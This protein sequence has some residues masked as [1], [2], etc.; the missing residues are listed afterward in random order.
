MDGKLVWV[1]WGGK[2]W[3]PAK[4]SEEIEGDVTFFGTCAD[5]SEN[6]GEATLTA[7]TPVRDFERCLAAGV[8][9]GASSIPEYDRKAF[10]AA[11][12]AALAHN[13]FVLR[14][15][16]SDAGG[17]MAEQPRTPAVFP[18][19]SLGTWSKR[20]D[21]VLGWLAAAEKDVNGDLEPP[22][23]KAKA[24]TA[25]AKAAKVAPPAAA[26]EGRAAAGKAKDGRGKAA[27]VAVVA[28]A[29]TKKKKQQKEK[30][31]KGR[32]SCKGKAA[33][34]AS[35]GGGS[36]SSSSSSSSI[37]VVGRSG[38]QRAAVSYVDDDDDDE[39]CEDCAH[40][41]CGIHFDDRVHG[42]R[43]ADRSD[44][45]DGHGESDAS[46]SDDDHDSSSSEEEMVDDS[47]SNSEEEQEED[48]EVSDD[49]DAFEEQPKKRKTTAKKNP[50]AK[51]AAAAAAGG[52]SASATEAA[53]APKAAA[54]EKDGSVSK[55]V[56]KGVFASKLQVK[57]DK[58]TARLL[59]GYGGDVGKW[60][61]ALPPSCN[62]MDPPVEN[63]TRFGARVGGVAAKDGE[64]E[65]EGEEGGKGSGGAAQKS[66]SSSSSSASTA[67]A[68]LPPAAEVLGEAAL[69]MLAK[70]EYQVGLVLGPTG[71][72]KTRVLQVRLLARG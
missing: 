4:R 31:T 49:S 12:D 3:W 44:S 64:E 40:G 19:Q 34:A 59:T 33:A 28:S 24:K 1:K 5:L 25:P 72:G 60:N 58:E 50:R 45:D 9:Q 67:A 65:E 16:C 10:M 23:A 38:R 70:S 37:V 66:S 17:G 15:V 55:P 18:G 8:A 57:Y 35:G 52:G 30:E 42:P 69:H 46:L 21:C 26:E 56:Y 20:M 48:E 71:S 7:K 68:A 22:K 54:R 39:D 63:V 61:A 43:G 53:G 13:A 51:G 27:A 2:S 36:S 47:G 32:G 11:V 6:A 29:A 62:N 41:D 14:G